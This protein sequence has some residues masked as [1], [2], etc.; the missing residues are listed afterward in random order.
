LL[1]EPQR[2]ARAR[3]CGQSFSVLAGR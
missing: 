1:A 3:T 2:I